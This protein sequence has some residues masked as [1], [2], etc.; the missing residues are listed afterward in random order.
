MTKNLTWL[1]K[2]FN[3]DKQEIIHNKNKVIREIL[4]TPK[5]VITRGPLEIKKESIWK[6]I[7][8]KLKGL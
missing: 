6:R 1:E 3:K 8:K 4:K 5:E 2:E 7:L